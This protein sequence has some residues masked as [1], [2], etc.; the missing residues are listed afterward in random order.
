MVV[1]YCQL[2]SIGS[3]L[4]SN[5][6]L[7]VHWRKAHHEYVFY[8]I[9]RIDSIGDVEFLFVRYLEKCHQAVLKGRKSFRLSPLNPSDTNIFHR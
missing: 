9:P 7:E 1:Q 6:K 5:E 3:H 2:D 4:L 8:S